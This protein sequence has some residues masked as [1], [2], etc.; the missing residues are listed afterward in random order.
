M[1]NSLPWS[2]TRW[3]PCQRCDRIPALPGR[4]AP[5]RCAETVPAPTVEAYVAIDET[6][7]TTGIAA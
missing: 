5:C 3:L 2:I 1:P 6:L 4:A 7:R